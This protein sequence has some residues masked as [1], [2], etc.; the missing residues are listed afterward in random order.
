MD[1]ETFKNIV[2][3]TK[4]G[5]AL[6]LYVVPGSKTS[7]LEHKEGE[8][9]F[10]S[11]ASCKHHGVNTDLLKWLSKNLG[12]EPYIV[13]GWSDRYKI[14]ELRGVNYKELLGKLSRLVLEN[15]LR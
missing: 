1:D 10:H 6:K 15:D 11:S 2:F 13:K 7:Y 3:N 5:I 8:L 9:I 12:G 14:V 4:N